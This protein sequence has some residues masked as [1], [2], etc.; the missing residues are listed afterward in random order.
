MTLNEIRSVVAEIAYRD[1]TFCV[2]TIGTTPDDV[3]YIKVRFKAD[4]QEWA[5]RKWIISSHA[6]ESEIL[7]TALLAVLQAEEHEA[8]EH[9]LFSGKPIYGPH[10]SARFL[11]DYCD[12][13]VAQDARHAPEVSRA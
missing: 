12:L 1:W 7:Q 3:V 4:G 5:G 11:R 13:P 9:F 8:R 10:Y 2:G 6:T